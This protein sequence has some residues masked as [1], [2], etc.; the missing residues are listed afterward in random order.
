MKKN[1]IRFVF[2]GFFERKRSELFRGLQLFLLIMFLGCPLFGVAQQQKV[3]IDVKQ[4]DVSVV[5]RQIKE[6]TKLN[7]VYDP[8]GCYKRRSCNGD[9]FRERCW[10]KSFAR[11]DDYV[12][13]T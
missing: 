11:S 12:E 13:G 10:G 2:S 8:T 6:Q 1:K 7:F 9:W 4:V 3:S 5:F